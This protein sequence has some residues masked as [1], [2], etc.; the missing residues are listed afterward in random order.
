M[1]NFPVHRNGP[2][3]RYIRRLAL[4]LA[5]L[6]PVWSLW[7]FSAMAAATPQIKTKILPNA[8]AGEPYYAKILCTDPDAEFTVYDEPGQPN[9]FG[10]SGLHCSKDGIISGTP[11]AAGLYYFCI[12]ATGAGGEHSQ[13]YTL[14]VAES[15]RVTTSPT[16]SPTEPAATEPATEPATELPTEPTTEPVTEPVPTEPTTEP[17]TEPVPTE[18]AATEPVTAEP[19][20]TPTDATPTEPEVPPVDPP[21]KVFPRWGA[22]LIVLGIIVAGT[23]AAVLIR[24]RK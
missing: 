2:Q 6:L 24:K 14:F 12:V 13:L 1:M 17:V 10:S 20:T 23:G 9:S 5:L 18:P 4:F 16:E 15:E 22:V 19:T 8:V 7:T 21:S 11:A 3:K